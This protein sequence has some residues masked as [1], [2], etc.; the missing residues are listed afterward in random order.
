[1]KLYTLICRAARASQESMALLLFTRET[2]SILVD[3]VL[4]KASKGAKR[5]REA[6]T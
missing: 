2:L 4:Q 6:G 1:M 3:P 5:K